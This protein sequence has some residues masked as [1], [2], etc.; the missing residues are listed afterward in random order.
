MAGFFG[1]SQLKGDVATLNIANRPSAP[2]GMWTHGTV[3]QKNFKWDVFHPNL[4][5]ENNPLGNNYHNYH[6]PMKN[7]QPVPWGPL[8]GSNSGLIICKN[9]RL[10]KAT[11]HVSSMN[12]V[13]A[14]FLSWGVHTSL[15]SQAPYSFQNSAPTSPQHPHHWQLANE[16]GQGERV[17]DRQTRANL[18]TIGQFTGRRR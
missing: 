17:G 6:L 15:A 8:E 3:L 5:P 12:L 16:M 10:E 11:S 7:N 2:S 18:A 1:I 4:S 9:M 14:H 13:M